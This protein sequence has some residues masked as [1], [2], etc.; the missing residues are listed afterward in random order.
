M[1]FYSSDRPEVELVS[2]EFINA[3]IP[4]EVRRGPALNG[5]ALNPA[6]AELWIQNDKDCH[7]AFMLCVQLGV[8]FAKR[9]AKKP[10]FH[11]AEP[12]PEPVE[13]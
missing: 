7:R 8:G 3:G 11:I 2:K 4:C 13:D 5:V 9:A 10:L 1:L 12:E 6:Q